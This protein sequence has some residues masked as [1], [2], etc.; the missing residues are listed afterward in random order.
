[1]SYVNAESG[2]A[3]TARNFA[4]ASRLERLSW[5]YRP[6]AARRRAS[7]AFKSCCNNSISNGSSI[8][9]FFEVT[10]FRPGKAFEAEPEL[11]SPPVFE[12]S[13]MFNSQG[14]N[15]RFVRGKIGGVWFPVKT[16]AATA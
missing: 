1:M 2:Q 12:V 8:R 10:S 11:F 9:G 15:Q 6:R 4:D 7:A 3:D 16:V 13:P 5:A 14:A